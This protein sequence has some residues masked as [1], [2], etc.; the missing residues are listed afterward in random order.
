MNFID[1]AILLILAVLV[2]GG[3]YRGF[4]EALLGIGATIASFLL[5]L[6]SVP[7]A[8]ASIKGHEKLYNMMLYYTE[9]SEYVAKTDVELTRT[10]IAN[11]SA[12]TIKTVIQNAEMPK[13][14]GGC[15]E[16]NIAT[17]AFKADGVT[18]LGDY[19]NQTIVSVVI[20]LLVLLAVFIVLRIL[21]AFLI[22]GACYGR[23]GFP[24]LQHADGP[25]GAGVGLIGG[26]L[27]LFVLFMAV[28]ICLVILPKLYDFLSESFFG[29]FFYKANL[30]LSLVPAT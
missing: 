20:N 16:R 21:C 26:V 17:E 1:I 14:M 3:Y 23:G 30:L 7:F 25:I 6:I 9:G 10:P 24:V 12:D 4:L 5:A 27:L 28:P 22:R 19:F 2:L 13:P 11:V 18:T 29:E 8:A 15:V